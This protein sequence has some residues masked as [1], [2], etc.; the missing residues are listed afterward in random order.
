MVISPAVRPNSSTTMARWLR[1][2]RKARSSS[3]RPLLSGTN[4]AGRSSVRTFS[5]GARCSFSRSFDIRM[6]MMFS[7]SP[8]YTGKRE[9][10]V[11]ITSSSMS[12]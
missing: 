5:S 12:S 9:C 10:A 3:F 1:F 7:R 6:P 4:T 2:T 8:W 11:R